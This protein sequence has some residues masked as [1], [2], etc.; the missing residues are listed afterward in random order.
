MNKLLNLITF[1]K[2]I[3]YLNLGIKLI[4]QKSRILIIIMKR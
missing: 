1:K 2:F 3:K 4:E